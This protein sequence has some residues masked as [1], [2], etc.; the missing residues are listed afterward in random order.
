[1]AIKLAH[2]L[3]C[4]NALRHTFKLHSVPKCIEEATRMNRDGKVL[5]RRTAE[6]LAGELTLGAVDRLQVAKVTLQIGAQA[7]LNEGE[8]HLLAYALTLPG[9]WFLCGPDSG[10]VRAMQILSILDRMVSFETLA[11]VAGYRL[12]KLPPHFSERWL[13]SHRLNALLESPMDR[14]A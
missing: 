4:W 3:G 7:D 14:P 5:V 10:T 12:K 13:S 9:I 6:E 2:D 11:S 1:M 8:R